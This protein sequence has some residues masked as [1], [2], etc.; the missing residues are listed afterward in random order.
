LLK[1]CIPGYDPV[2]ARLDDITALLAVMVKRDRAAADVIA[3]LSTAGLGSSRIARLVGTS[4]GYVDNVIA[5]RKS[6]AAKTTG[7]TA[8]TAKPGPVKRA[9]RRA[10]S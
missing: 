3:D 4:P 8:K 6:T 10:A 1:P 9:A 5:R 7:T 2:F